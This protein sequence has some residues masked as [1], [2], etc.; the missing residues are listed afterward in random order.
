MTNWP[1]R[2]TVILIFVFILAPV[3]GSRGMPVTLNQFR[4]VTVFYEYSPS[5]VFSEPL[6]VP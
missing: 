6:G 2:M 3:V 5:C 1:D 4:P